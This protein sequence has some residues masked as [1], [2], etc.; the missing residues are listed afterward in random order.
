VEE[1]LVRSV[2]LSLPL[3]AALL[4]AGVT[5]NVLVPNVLVP[6]VLVP[7]NAWVDLNAWVL[8]YRHPCC[9]AHTS[10]LRQDEFPVGGPN[11]QNLGSAAVAEEHAYISAHR[12]DRPTVEVALNVQVVLLEPLNCLL[13]GAVESV[14][15]GY[16]DAGQDMG[17]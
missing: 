8:H 12:Q 17:C 10:G 3:H 16:V 15:L 5:L 7:P 13:Q 9:V 2:S 4:I 6:N 1:K 14:P 11:R